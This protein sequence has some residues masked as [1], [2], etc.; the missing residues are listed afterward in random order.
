MKP[1]S[2]F[3]FIFKDFIYLFIYL[4]TYLERK[5]GRTRGRE[6]P[7]SCPSHAPQLG[8]GLQPRHCPDQES[9]QSVTICF[10]G[11]CSTNWVMLVR[12]RHLVYIFSLFFSLQLDV[13][14]FLFYYL[15]KCEGTIHTWPSHPL[16]KAYILPRTFSLR[17]PSSSPRWAATS[18]TA[19]VLHFNKKVYKM[20][21]TCQLDI[22][23]H[24]GK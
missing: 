12:A 3:L 24:G 1:S 22:N 18:K 20:C 8:T 5:G 19:E 15:H 7:V 21:S 14:T 13:K 10:V 2:L 4:L 23:L 6:T 9:N 16:L 17:L 11:W